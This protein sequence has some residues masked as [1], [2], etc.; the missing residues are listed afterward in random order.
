MQI[1][2]GKQ[3]R[4][5]LCSL[6][7][8][9]SFYSTKKRAWKTFEDQ[10][11]FLEELSQRLGF[12]TLNDWYTITHR[13][14]RRSGGGPL[15][16][17]HSGNLFNALKHYYPQHNWDMLQMNKI[18]RNYW[19]SVDNQRSFLNKL[20]Q[21]YNIESISEWILKLN[22]I[23]KKEVQ[24]LSILAKYNNNYVNMLKTIYPSHT[25]SRVD[26][27]NTH[28]I[29]NSSPHSNT[30]TTNPSSTSNTLINDLVQPLSQSSDNN[31]NKN[32]GLN[33]EEYRR[34]RQIF[35]DIYK[36]C[37]FTSIDQ[38]LDVNQKKIR[39][40]CG[41]SLFSSLLSSCNSLNN[42]INQI[43]INNDIN[44][45][46]N[47]DNNINNNNSNNNSNN[48]L[49]TE[50]KIKKKKRS[51]N[52][53]LNLLYILQ[54]VYSDYHFFLSKIFANISYTHRNQYW[55]DPSIQI[56]YLNHLFYQLELKQL[57]D[58]LTQFNLQKLMID[59]FASIFINRFY[60]SNPY[61][62]L[63]Q[64]YKN[65]NWNLFLFA[66]KIPNFFNSFE[67]D[68]KYFDYLI[69]HLLSNNRQI[70]SITKFDFYLYGGKNMIKKYQ[71]VQQ[72]F[73][74]L[75]PDFTFPSATSN[76][77]FFRSNSPLHYHNNN[78]HHCNYENDIND[79]SITFG[80]G[81][82]RLIEETHQNISS[83]LHQNISSVLHQN[84]EI[85]YKDGSNNK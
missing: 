12:T 62:C 69:A 25:W 37:S 42:N 20:A 76:I 58:W 24:I 41:D 83:V 19:N 9:K 47:D 2:I 65:Y 57:D 70:D 74:I 59:P 15:L 67:N 50:I 31:N 5:Y 11:Q 60:E 80:D 78:N 40:I 29:A 55:S 73:S 52:N 82:E 71:N 84:N 32:E 79:N 26:L 36:S 61:L 68:K 44:N 85:E 17:I 30:S 3:R 51:V 77:S 72:I 33:E 39:K 66:M 81:D 38:L 4:I 21:K 6:E 63:F 8:R 22:D 27:L 34:L 64:L 54:K 53:S 18:T 35:D 56:S 48:D 75:L 46:N 43:N 10:K 14:I 1:R 13:E 16:N 28:S 49:N 7:G 23:K 45:I